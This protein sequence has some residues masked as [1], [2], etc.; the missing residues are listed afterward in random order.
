MAL[1]LVACGVFLIVGAGMITESYDKLLETGDYS[2]REKE[3]K[4]RT[5]FFPGIYWCVI[6]AIYLGISFYTNNWHR[7]WIIY[8][9]AGV[10]YAAIYGIRRAIMLGKR[11]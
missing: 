1:S 2:P 8:A 10:L 6:T 4:R 9:V 11:K 7:T 5:E 3:M